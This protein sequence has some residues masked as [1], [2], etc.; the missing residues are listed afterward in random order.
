M[1]TF[2]PAPILSHYATAQLLWSFSLLSPRP[3]SDYRTGLMVKG[4]HLR[5]PHTACRPIHRTPARAQA[6]APHPPHPRPPAPGPLHPTPRHDPRLP[7]SLSD[8]G[9][10]PETR[11]AP[12]CSAHSFSPVHYYTDV[13][14]STSLSSH[15]MP[16][17]TEGSGSFSV[18]TRLSMAALHGWCRDNSLGTDEFP[19]PAP[20]PRC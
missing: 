14:A 10:I 15:T 13:P 4:S 3:L 16:V 12:L 1:V 20:T 2:C 8:P 7:C 5:P 9:P 17:R 19:H 18:H 11:R 6:T